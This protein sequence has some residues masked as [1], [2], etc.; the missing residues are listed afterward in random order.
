MIK[1]LAIFVLLLSPFVGFSQKNDKPTDS[2][3]YYRKATMKAQKAAF[4]SLKQTTLYKDYL[5]FSKRKNNYSGMSLFATAV[6]SDY[7]QFSKELAA[8][9]FPQLNTMGYGL[10][11]GAATKSAHVIFDFYFATTTFESTS[12]KGAETIGSSL[13]NFLQ[14]D[15]GYDVLNS[16]RCSIYP[17]VG[18]SARSASLR[19]SN[20]GTPNPTP[21][22][23]ATLVIGDK[24]VYANS[25]R[26]GYQAGLGIDLKLSDGKNGENPILIFA[27]A[28]INRPF[29]KDTYKTNGVSY[30]PDIDKGNLNIAFGFKFTSRY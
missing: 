9:G 5:A 27:K 29:W 6:Q 18:I 30:D 26:L 12:K 10:G 13:A 20:K 19:Y 15:L 8:G 21:T 11:F 1:Q 25:V 17:F 2:A 22:G 4:E 28:G 16:N 3:N 14:L 24:N 23:L 7:G